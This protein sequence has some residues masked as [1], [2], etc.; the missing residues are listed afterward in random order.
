MIVIIIIMMI[1]CFKWQVTGFDNRLVSFG[2]I[3]ERVVPS[4]RKGGCRWPPVIKAPHPHHPR[5]GTNTLFFPF[6]FLFFFVK[7]EEEDNFVC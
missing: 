6:S 5:V 7:E 4:G 2:P 1:P 3:E